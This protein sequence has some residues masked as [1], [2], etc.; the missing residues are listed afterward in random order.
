M[1]CA[2]IHKTR[3]VL[4]PARHPIQTYSDADVLTHCSASY[5]SVLATAM[6]TVPVAGQTDKQIG[7]KSPCGSRILTRVSHFS[8]CHAGYHTEVTS[9]FIHLPI[10]T[11]YSQTRL[12]FSFYFPGEM[13][14]STKDKCGRRGIPHLRELPYY[15]HHP[16]P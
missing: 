10:R 8:N 6:A 9:R 1:V 15:T 4:V 11:T 16:L 2:R 5:Y 13:I 12:F 7:V 14:A 3:Y